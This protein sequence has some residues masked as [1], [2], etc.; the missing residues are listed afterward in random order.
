MKVAMFTAPGQVEIQ[1]MARPTVKEGEILVKVDACGVCAT[2]VKTI[3]KGHRVWKPPRVMGHEIAGHIV[4]INGPSHLKVGDRVVVAPYVPCGHCYLCMRGEET[5]CEHLFDEQPDPGGFAEFVRCPQRLAERGL[6]PIPDGLSSAVATLAEAIACAIRAVR[7]SRVVPGTR[8]LVVG[9]GPMGL[10][11][12]AAAR[13][14]GADKV[15]LSGLSP[16][17][18]KVAQ[19]HYADVIV[20]IEEVDL[21][22]IVEDETEGHGADVVIVAVASPAVVR[23]SLALVRR[24][25][26]LNIFAGQPA[27]S[28]IEM[29]LSEIHYTEMTITGSFG[30]SPATIREALNMAAHRV[31]FTPIVTREFQISDF[32]EAIQYS[33]SMEGLRAVVTMD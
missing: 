4:E 5:Q 12:A 7:D 17:R 31:D 18:L 3:L 29:D 24:G 10:I 26:T 22:R 19:R 28:T 13:A 30:S 1:E 23:N 27:G 21:K 6:I 2:D 9:D 8:V 16:E 25:G 33:V 11:N 14:Y 15:I 32:M 20:N